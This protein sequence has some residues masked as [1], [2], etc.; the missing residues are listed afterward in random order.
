MLSLSCIDTQVAQICI[1]MLQSLARSKQSEGHIGM[2][3]VAAVSSVMSRD[4]LQLTMYP[5]YREY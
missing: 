2:T 5:E 3:A 1:R 4:P